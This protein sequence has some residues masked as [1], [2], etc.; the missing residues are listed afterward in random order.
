VC[1]CV[2]VCV[3]QVEQVIAERNILATTSC[4]YVVRLYYAFKTQEN[5]CLAMEFL[6]GGDL[7]APLIEVG[8][9]DEQVAK[10]YIAEILQALE[11][12][13]SKK[14]IHRGMSG[15]DTHRH[16]NVVDAQRLL[17]ACSIDRHCTCVGCSITDL[18]PDN[19]LI[20]NDGHLKLTD[21]GLSHLGLHSMLLDNIDH[22][23]TGTC[24][25]R[26]SL[27]R[28][29]RGDARVLGQDRGQR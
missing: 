17:R 23:P 16:D 22:R 25:L 29:H 21:F 6:S 18:K 9:L 19:I 3:A 15:M 4:E 14:I 7:C 10:W 8:A 5:L 20:A 28:S 1:V 27:T 13:H 26:H 12:L 2:C 11:Y 24:R